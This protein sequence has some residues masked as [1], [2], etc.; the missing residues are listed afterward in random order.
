MKDLNDSKL[1]PN[2][3]FTLVFRINVGPKLFNFDAFSQKSQLIII[4]LLLHKKSETS[5]AYA[6][7]R[8]PQI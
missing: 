8:D 2:E 4:E 6:V 1:I 7:N 3:S 5:H